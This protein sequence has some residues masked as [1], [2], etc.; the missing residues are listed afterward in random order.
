MLNNDFYIIPGTENLNL[1]SIDGIPDIAKFCTSF[2]FIRREEEY[3][4]IMIFSIEDYYEFYD[5]YENSNITEIFTN[6]KY[7]S[8]KL[9]SSYGVINMDFTFEYLELDLQSLFQISEDKAETNVKISCNEKD[10]KNLIYTVKTKTNMSITKALNSIIDEFKRQVLIINQ[11]FEKSID[12]KKDNI[13]ELKEA[14]IFLSNKR[15]FINTAIKYLS[16]FLSSSSTEK[17][18]YIE[19][20]VI[21]NGLNSKE[22]L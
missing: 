14:F 11:T 4:I 10:L 21:N 18:E 15:D 1:L 13:D 20:M 16:N 7:N 2:S 5:K 9:Y 3:D 12:L 17:N 6:H 8:E 19:N 22:D